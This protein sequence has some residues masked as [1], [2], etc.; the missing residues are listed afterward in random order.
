MQPCTHICTNEPSSHTEK[1]ISLTYFAATNR[2]PEKV[3]MNR[4][5]QAS[6]SNLTAHGIIVYSWT[7][8][9]LSCPTT[10]LVANFRGLFCLLEASCLLC[11][12]LGTSDKNNVMSDDGNI[13]VCQQSLTSMIS[14]S[15]N[16]NRALTHSY[17]L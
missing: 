16:T 1:Q 11:D 14:C 17:E 9:A 13:L 3:G 15:F 8:I 10:K 12:H 6:W 2:P 7:G 5:F 4:H